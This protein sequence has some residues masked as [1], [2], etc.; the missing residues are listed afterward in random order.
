MA[1]D[2]VDTSQGQEATRDRRQHTSLQAL[3]WP[4]ARKQDR[5]FQGLRACLQAP[6][7]DFDKAPAWFRAMPAQQRARFLVDGE[8]IIYR[9]FPPRTRARWLVPQGL[10]QAVVASL[11]KGACGAH[12]GVTKTMAALSLRFFWPRMIDA[13]KTFIKRCERCQ[14][15]KSGTPSA[16]SGANAQ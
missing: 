14:R 7:G 2:L 4:L 5:E 6:G 9:G 15:A 8:N 10:R 12:M 13:V 11:H 16:E 3:D 1:V